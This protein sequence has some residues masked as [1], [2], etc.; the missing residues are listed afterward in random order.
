MPLLLATPGADTNHRVG[1]SDMSVDNVELIVVDKTLAEARV[2]LHSTLL[3]DQEQHPFFQMTTNKM[4][5]CYYLRR[6]KGAR[7]RGPATEARAADGDSQSR[8]QRSW[9][10]LCVHKCSSGLLSFPDELGD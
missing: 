2:F 8:V 4:V 9:L 10:L 1:R 7:S 6:V 5:F 3:P